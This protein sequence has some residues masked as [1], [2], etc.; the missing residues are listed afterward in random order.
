VPVIIAGVVNQNSYG[1][2]A[3]PRFSDGGAEC[4]N[5][6]KIAVDEMRHLSIFLAQAIDEGLRRVAC[7]VDEAHFCPLPAKMLDKALTDA[8]STSG[9]EHAAAP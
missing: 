1:S 8:A 9:N 2:V 3:L 5:V 7:N 6:A 4:F